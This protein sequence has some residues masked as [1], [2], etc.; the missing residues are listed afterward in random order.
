MP[1][2]VAIIGADWPVYEQFCPNFVGMQEGL[3]ALDIEYK[4]FGCRPTLRI[5]RVI[6]YKPDLVI[7][8]LV[9]VVKNPEWRE[10]IRKGLP[11]AKIVMWYGDLRNAE[12]GRQVS[13]DMSEIDAMFVSNDEQSEYYKRLWK[14]PSCEFLPLGSPIYDRP[15]NKQYVFD[16]VF[17]GGVITGAGFL[18]RARTMW[19]YR[20]N[21][22]R[23]LDGDQRKPQL[24]AKIFKEMPTIYRSSKVVLDQS[25]FTNIKGYTSNRFWI[26]TG[27]AGFA[28]TKRWPGCEDFYPSGTRA[29]FDTFEESL[30]LR[31]FYLKNPE[32]REKIR[33]AGYEHARNHTY[34]KR[35]V[36]MFLSLYASEK[37]KID[38]ARVGKID[39][40][41]SPGA[42]NS[43]KPDPRLAGDPRRKGSS[44]ETNGR[45]GEKSFIIKN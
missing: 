45:G 4:L 8:G 14:V 19:R 25:H 35:F 30:K 22:L 29:Y 44:K 3:H 10:K 32:E 18:D 6:A 39:P 20:D 13:A 41:I 43:K 9:D 34:D 2:R 24:R 7:Y 31:D 40:G 26:I 12:T 23:I 27:S 38:H 15:V 1:D 17:I 28:L 36:K 33:L 16:F 11:D 37:N 5:D 21:G 42:S